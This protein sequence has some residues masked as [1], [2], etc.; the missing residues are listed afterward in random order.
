M[1][2]F[3]RLL[4]RHWIAF[5]WALAIAAS[6]GAGAEPAEVD[7]LNLPIEDLLRMEVT[8]VSKH[9]QPLSEAAAAV[10]VITSEPCTGKTSTHCVS[11]VRELVGAPLATD[12]ARRP[13]RES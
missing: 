4:Q 11:T 6:R 3:V 2:A 5:A 13:T 7:L 12:P 8:T 1:T 9:A 10:T